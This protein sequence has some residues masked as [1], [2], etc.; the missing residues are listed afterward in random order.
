MGQFDKAIQWVNS[1]GQFNRGNPDPD[2]R[3]NKCSEIN[4]CLGVNKCTQL[5][6]CTEYNK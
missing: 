3:F 5:N 4:I 1:M 6:K 2:P